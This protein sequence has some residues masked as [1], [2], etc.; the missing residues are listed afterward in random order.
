[1]EM[2]FE[3]LFLTFWDDPTYSI[4][5]A[6]NLR[7]YDSLYQF[8]KHDVPN[9]KH[10]IDCCDEQG[11]RHSCI[12]LAARGATGIHKHSVVLLKG[13]CYIAVSDML[14]A[15][16]LPELKL[17]WATK[18]DEA[19]CFGVHYSLENDCLISH[20]ELEIARVDF[21]GKII[22]AAGGKDIFT[23]KLRLDEKYVYVT[24]F[25]EEVYQIKMETGKSEIVSL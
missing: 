9:S 6:D 17:L 5:S 3:S 23:G 1:M 10:G 14:C 22:W 21:T 7:Q 12:L 13:K 16:T 19:T 25:N 8:S 4:G 2:K 20:G 18:V 24:D 15:L 11:I